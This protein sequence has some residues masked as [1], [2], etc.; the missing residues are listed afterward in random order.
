MTCVGGNVAVNDW[1]KSFD[2][3]LPVLLQVLFIYTVAFS[4]GIIVVG[5]CMI[6]VNGRSSSSLSVSSLSE[7]FA[8][9]LPCGSAGPLGS[10][11]S[12]IRFPSESDG[13]GPHELFWNSPSLSHFPN[14]DQ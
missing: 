13:V 4:I 7:L 3:L 11:F 9:A 14:V 6:I 12:P 8:I 5:R 10:H 2:G 1:Y